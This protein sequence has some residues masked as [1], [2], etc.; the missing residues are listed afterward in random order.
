MIQAKFADKTHWVRQTEHARAA[1]DI[2]R[3]WNYVGRSQLEQQLICAATRHHDD[4]WAALEERGEPADGWKALD[5]LTMEGERKSEVWLRGVEL[6]AAQHPYV[7]LLVALH[8]HRLTAEH[9]DD[10]PED[11]ERLRLLEEREETLREQVTEAEQGA[12]LLAA[13]EKDC[14]L[15]GLFDALQLMTI[16][17]LPQ[18]MEVCGERCYSLEWRENSVAIAP[19]PFVEDVVHLHCRSVEG[20]TMQWALVENGGVP[21]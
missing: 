15:L 16:G 20:V 3:A 4:G 18:S 14:L 1:A 9:D 7:G 6:A 11:R 2:A 21:G 17:G 12:T 13:A 19:W 8:A 10:S 5:F